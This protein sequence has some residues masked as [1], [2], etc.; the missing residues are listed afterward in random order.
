MKALITVVSVLLLCS[1]AGE[2]VMNGSV[3]SSFNGNTYTPGPTTADDPRLG[4]PQFYMNDDKSPAM[5]RAAP[6]PFQFGSVD[7]F[8]AANCQTR[9]YSAAYCTQACS[10]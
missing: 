7:N 1:C 5:Q 4:S 8:C 10:R 9:H 3:Q 2:P 6:A